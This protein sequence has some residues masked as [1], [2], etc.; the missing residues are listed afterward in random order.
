MI[1][2]KDLVKKYG[3]HTVLKGI[4]FQVP[5]GKVVGLLGPNGAGKSTTMN[6]LT[7]YLASTEGE[8]MIGGY[9]IAEHPLEAKKQFGYL[10]ELPPVYVDMTV[11][12]YLKFVG[13]LKGFK[14][15]KLRDSVEDVMKSIRIDDKRN[16]LIKQLSKGYRQRVGLAQA[17][18]GNPPLL[19]LDEPMVGLDPNQII[20]MR[21]LILGLKGKHTIL[22]SSHIISE[23]EAVSDQI[24]IINNG[25]VTVE[26]TAEQLA[27]DNSDKKM[28]KLVIKGDKSAIENILTQ[29][30]LLADIQYIKEQEKGVYIYSAKSISGQDVRD[31]MF[32][33]LAANQFVVYNIAV[34]QLSLEDVFVKLTK[35]ESDNKD[36]KEENQDECDL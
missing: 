6:I 22:I 26:D 18:L 32:S 10:P 16:I 13:E 3:K 29:S 34:E 9:N 31:K 27:I 24:I 36:E 25:V 33:L 7:G 15:Q 2:V 23:I 19:I 14:K 20:E 11:Y 30:N 4:S 17:L 5:D 21:E 1:E 8:V 28:L 12:E 35:N